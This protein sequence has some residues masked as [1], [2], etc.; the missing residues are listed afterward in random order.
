MRILIVSA[1]FYPANSP[2]SFRTTEL[3]KELASQGH[4]VVVVTPYKGIIQAEL[5]EKWKIQV[6]DPAKDCHKI[7]ICVFS[8]SDTLQIS[9]QSIGMVF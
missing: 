1:A 7:Y 3:S 6:E 8:S 5:A 9:Q 2:R 4:E